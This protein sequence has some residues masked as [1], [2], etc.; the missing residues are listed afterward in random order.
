MQLKKTIDKYPR[1]KVLESLSNLVINEADLQSSLNEIVLQNLRTVTFGLGGL[2]TGLSMSHFLLLPKAIAFPLGLVAAISAAI[3]VAIG[4]IIRMWEMP[5]RW[6]NPIGVG[7]AGLVLINSFLHL[8]L[9][10]E[11]EQTTNLMLFA[12][13]AGFFFLS[14]FWFIL[15]L[16][17][18]CFGWVL[19]VWELGPSSYWIHFAFG[20]LIAIVLSI[21][22]HIV[23]VQT[24]V[25]LEKLKRQDKMVKKELEDALDRTQVDE[26]NFRSLVENIPDYILNVDQS[27]KILFIN[28]PFLGF[29]EE[30][31]L[32]KTVYDFMTSESQI[33]VQQSLKKVFGNGEKDS[34][35]NIGVSTDNSIYW[36]RTRVGPIKSGSEVISAILVGTDITERKRMEEALETSE[37]KLRAIFDTAVNG[38]ITIDEAGLIE[39]YNTSAARIFGYDPEEVIGKNL[40]LLMPEPYHSQHDGYIH[41]YINTGIARVIGIGQ[42]TKGQRKDGT[43]FPMELAVSE[44]ILNERRWFTGV[45]RDITERVEA[46][47]IRTHLENELR[48]AYEKI[49]RELDLAAEIQTSL[50]P[51][52]NPSYDGFDCA[53]SFIPARYVSGD[54]YDFIS[55]DD[56]NCFITLADIAGKGIPAALLTFTTHS[57]LRTEIRLNKSPKDILSNINSSMYDDLT[58]SEMFITMF[59]GKLN[60]RLGRLTFANAGHTEIL[61]WQYGN[62]KCV[63]LPASGLPIGI[64]A[65]APITEETIALRPGDMLVFYSDGI[66]E[67]ENPQG[68]LFGIERL[69]K[70]LTDQPYRP[71]SDMSQLI[72]E[73]IEDFQVVSTFSDDITLIVLKVL[74]RIIS[75]AYPAT[76]DHLNEMSLLVQQTAHPYGSE[77]AYQMELAASE[78]LTNVIKHAYNQLTGEIRGQITLMLDKLQLDIYDDGNPFDLTSSVPKTTSGELKESGF[79]LSIARQLTDELTYS[80]STP[81]GN[82]WHLVKSSNVS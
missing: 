1:K 31:I 15:I 77:F 35:E 29:S 72:T 21:L 34:F 40:N 46:E 62:N 22:I 78:I 82:H 58:Q 81:D 24:I 32:G 42:E 70:I 50:L 3:L 57:L 47:E 79:G 33:T 8:Y 41:N 61:W 27:G 26:D 53:T 10:S 67:A 4:V 19:L 80:P 36:F 54:I 68:E 64:I 71:A 9:T 43:I 37:A 6:V 45:I 38:I 66:T 76:L 59:T 12:V 20:L 75:F 11:P 5:L 44:V 51:R 7:I 30:E 17:V 63:S 56:D 60:T 48:Q 14:H 18:T 73:A 23:R 28:Y 65:D 74:P 55:F 52:N 16:L 49:Q 13:G 39:S 25:R 69:K 2:Y